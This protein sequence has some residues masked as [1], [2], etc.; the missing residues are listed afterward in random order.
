LAWSQVA[1]ELLEQVFVSSRIAE[2][3]GHGHR[4][5]SYDVYSRNED[6]RRYLTRQHPNLNDLDPVFYLTD[7]ARNLGPLNPVCL[8]C[9][10]LT[11]KPYTCLLVKGCL[12]YM[13]GKGDILNGHPK[14]IYKDDIVH[15]I[16]P[17]AGFENDLAKLCVD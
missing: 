4:C 11:V 5:L 2:E 10:D 17:Y 13:C 1:L 12:V 9:Y 15:G 8:C 3:D 16:T 7:L 6:D 14:R